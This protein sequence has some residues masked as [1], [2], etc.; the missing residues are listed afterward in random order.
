LN[1]IVNA[2]PEIVARHHGEAAEPEK[3]AEHWQL[4]AQRVDRRFAH[5]ETISHFRNVTD[6]LTALK[7]SADRTRQAAGA[8]IAIAGAPSCNAA[9]SLCEGREDARLLSR[10]PFGAM[11]WCKIRGK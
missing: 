5:H 2:S 7:L 8:Q 3:A 6:T 1:N 9:R 4:A 10:A 11:G